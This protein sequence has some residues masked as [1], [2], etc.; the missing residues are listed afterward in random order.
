MDEHWELTPSGLRLRWTPNGPLTTA[1][2]VL[3]DPKPENLISGDSEPYYQP[4][5]THSPQW[6]WHP[7]SKEFFTTPPISSIKVKCVDVADLEDQWVEL[8]ER[9]SLPPS[10]IGSCR[11]EN[12][13]DDITAVYETNNPPSPPGGRRRR[14]R[15]A[16]MQRTRDGPL[17]AC[18]GSKRPR[19]RAR[20][21]KLTVSVEARPRAGPAYLTLHDYVEQVHPWLMGLRRDILR[22]KAIEKMVLCEWEGPED[23]LLDRWGRDERVLFV[24]CFLG[25]SP[26]HPGFLDE[27]EGAGLLHAQAG[28][29][30]P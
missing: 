8:H 10:T 6:P 5:T 28:V 17:I 7:I 18:C 19:K 26:G 24:D 16:R 9:D 3:A 12:H 22:A 30:N 13:D 23:E 2:S 15:L 25:C 14:L 20:A 4:A 11:A 21:W 27:E 29:Q 1:I